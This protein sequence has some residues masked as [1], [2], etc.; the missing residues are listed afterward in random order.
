MHLLDR[1]HSGHYS[2]SIGLMVVSCLSMVCLCPSNLLSQGWS[3]LGPDSIGW[4]D[5]DRLDVSSRSGSPVRIL[6]RTP[7][8]IAARMGGKWRMVLP[9]HPGS[10]PPFRT[11]Y[12]RARFSP[13]NDS[14]AIIVVDRFVG[15]Y[16]LYDL[17][18]VDN[19]YADTL[20]SPVTSTGLCWYDGTAFVDVP[21]HSPGHLYAL[22][23]CS[24]LHSSDNGKSWDAFQYTP[25][26]DPRLFAIDR[27][28][29]SV[30]YYGKYN[31]STDPST[32]FRSI[33]QGKS[34]DT[35]LTVPSGQGG[36]TGI[37]VRGNTI[38]LCGPAGFQRS[39]D[40][41]QSWSQMIVPG[42]V[43]SMSRDEVHPRRLYAATPNGILRSRNEGNTWTVYNNTLP[44]KEIRD[45][46]KD[47][48]S[49]TL[50]LATDQGVLAVFDEV[51]TDAAEAF[52]SSPLHFALL[53]NFPNP[54]NPSTDI[55]FSL[56][57]RAFVTLKIFDVLGR[58][59]SRLVAETLQPGDH[60]YRWDASGMSSGLYF[61]Q[62]VAGELIE[63][64]K[65]I[66]LR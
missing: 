43:I 6:A 26:P 57:S 10:Y 59:V 13:W 22:T 45:L 16:S 34:W 31:W 24:L 38:L 14:T 33:N 21:V 50:Y 11:S 15:E 54:F 9:N 64:R 65:M 8:G 58:E 55:V 37:F 56:P 41:G 46:V 32:L 27:S 52:P 66:F 29:D 12:C 48:R 51:V 36:W 63:T 7:E 20:W 18:Y 47:P 62:L 2:L 23:L 61:Y 1:W 28:N 60:S 40:N 25:W 17:A 30:L 39:T 5:L 35:L 3:F 4:R 19:S 49:D 53:Q 44:T 42:G